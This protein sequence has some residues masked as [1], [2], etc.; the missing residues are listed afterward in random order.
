MKRQLPSRPNLDQL[1]HQAR[2]LLN[3]H[4]VGDEDA[5]RR[6]RESHPRLSQ[7]SEADVRA[8]RFTLSVAQLVIAREYGFVSWPKLKE[9]VEEARPQSSDARWADRKNAHSIS[10]CVVIV[11]AGATLR[12]NP[13]AWENRSCVHDWSR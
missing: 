8:A 4:R 7:A 13:I 6:I 12:K 11:A 1:K 5:V 10:I 9:Y 2:D 3:A